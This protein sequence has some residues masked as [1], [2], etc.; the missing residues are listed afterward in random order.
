MGSEVRT[1]GCYGSQS[2]VIRADAASLSIQE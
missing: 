2:A 1:T